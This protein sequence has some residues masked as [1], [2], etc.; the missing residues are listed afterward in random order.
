MP[1]YD[2]G[3]NNTIFT[4]DRSL[5]SIPTTTTSYSTR[6]SRMLEKHTIFCEFWN[7]ATNS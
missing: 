1:E 5:K 4:N 3:K 7:L 6:N 2:V